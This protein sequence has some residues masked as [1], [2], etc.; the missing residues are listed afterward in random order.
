M[1]KDFKEKKIQIRGLKSIVKA[2]ADQFTSNNSNVERDTSDL[3]K[4]INIILLIVAQCVGLTVCPTKHNRYCMADEFV[5]LIHI[6][7]NLSVPI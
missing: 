7:M 2:L 1:T 6:P 4:G 5:T 3:R